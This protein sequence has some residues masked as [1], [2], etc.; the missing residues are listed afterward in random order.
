MPCFQLDKLLWFPPV[1][2]AED[3]GLLA[4]G[5]DL[6]PQRLLFAYSLG[7]F[8]WYNEG[9]PILWWSPD[10]RCIL[11]PGEIHISRSLRKTLRRNI[12]RVSFNQ[13]FDQVIQNC[14]DD[15]CREGGEGSWISPEMQ[16][17]YRNL[18][19]LGF[20]HSVECWQGDM[21]VG[22]L[23][24]LC[25]GRCFF[26]ES[27]FSHRSDASKVALVGLACRLEAADFELIDCQQTTSHL[28]SLGAF[29]ISRDEFLSRLKKG[30]VRPEL[31]FS[32][33]FP[34]EPVET[35]LLSAKLIEE[36]QL[37]TR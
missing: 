7:I 26:G 21:L 11:S 9:E 37:Q 15:R 13:A 33:D 8:P 3:C 12:Y 31:K 6:S 5:G 10:P 29:E 16:A 19:R 14:R 17:A 24:G 32:S 23:Y 2:A 20:A 30:E 22:G 25:L 34:G 28:L 18:H 4:V 35:L 27:M 36:S 1:D